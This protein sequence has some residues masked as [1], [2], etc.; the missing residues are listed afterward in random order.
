MLT[1]SAT[2][3]AEISLKLNIDMTEETSWVVGAI[4]ARE[5]M[6]LV[7][8]LAD[9]PS[10]GLLLARLLHKSRRRFR[11][12]SVIRSRCPLGLELNNLVEGIKLPFQLWLVGGWNRSD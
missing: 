10:G 1:L 3:A 12:S 9:F 6:A 4:K 11:V 5:F 2:L 7:D 8:H